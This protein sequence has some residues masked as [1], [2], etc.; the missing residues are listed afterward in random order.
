MAFNVYKPKTP[1]PQPEPLTNN[2]KITIV[3]I[4]CTFKDSKVKMVIGHAFVENGKQILAEQFASKI[5]DLDNAINI[6]MK[7]GGIETQT[8]LKNAL[9]QKFPEFSEQFIIYVGQKAI[10][11]ADGEGNCDWTT[12]LTYFTEEV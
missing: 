11:W 9:M 5:H 2:E 4:Y 3:D 10:A 1:E 8:D 12:F 6:I 7:S